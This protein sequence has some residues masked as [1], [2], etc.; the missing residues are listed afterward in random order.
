[1]AKEKE[2]TKE[3]QSRK[4]ALM[5]LKSVNL[6]NLATSYQVHKSGQFGE[7]GDS[8]ME[9]YKYLPSF[10]KGV[11]GYDLKGGEEFDL[12]QSSLLASR[13]DGE[14]YTGNFSEKKIMGECAM[15]V[16]ESL[17]AITVKDLMELMGSKA[18]IPEEYNNMYLGSLNPKLSEEEKDKLKNSI[19]LYTSLIGSYNSYLSQKMVSEALGESAKNIPKGLEKI[20]IGDK[21]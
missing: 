10:Q 5:N 7:T 21:E 20:L 8:A 2:L 14:R 17:N 1:M 15:I 18:E 6:L 4:I 3:E 13:E 16:Q 11:K 19:Q 12:I 9:I